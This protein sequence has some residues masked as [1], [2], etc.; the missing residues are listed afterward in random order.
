MSAS[1]TPRDGAGAGS[2][3]LPP[4]APTTPRKLA[5]ED[6]DDAFLEAITALMTR[7]PKPPRARSIP[8]AHTSSAGIGVQMLGG[9]WGVMG[10]QA[11]PVA[12]AVGGGAGS[13]QG[14]THTHGVRGL[15][16]KPFCS[17]KGQDKHHYNHQQLLDQLRK[18]QGVDIPR[19]QELSDPVKRTY[20]KNDVFEL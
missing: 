19:V 6:I 17:W 18:R 16:G 4:P 3:I 2:G 7:F 20:V 10:T 13:G 1:S 11:A 5:V 9:N 14:E 8:S 15:S 12:P